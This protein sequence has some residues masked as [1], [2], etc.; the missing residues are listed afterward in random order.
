MGLTN[1]FLKRGCYVW[2][3]YEIKRLEGY[4]AYKKAL[5]SK[6]QVKW[7][8]LH[9]QIFNSTVIRQMVVLIKIEQ[10]V[11]FGCCE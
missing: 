9:F 8:V 4:G 5:S 10:V 2:F 6:G 3:S 7:R 11:F 1:Q